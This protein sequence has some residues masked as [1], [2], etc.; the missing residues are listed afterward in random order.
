[1]PQNEIEIIKKKSTT[2]IIYLSFRNFLIQSI[3]AVGYFLLTF[4]M[5]VAEAGLFDIVNEIVSIFGYFSDL[6]FV[7]A[8]IQKKDKPKKTELRTA[9]TFQQIVVFLSLLLIFLTYP[10]IKANRNMA[11]NCTLFFIFN[12]IS[13]NYSFSFTGKKL[14]I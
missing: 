1:M 7:A 12:L 3:S 11:L 13:K 10:T 2:G 5:G 9:F 6:G 8:L 4:F 14:K